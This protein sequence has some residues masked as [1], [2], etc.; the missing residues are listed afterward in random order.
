MIAY[1]NN[2]VAVEADIP[3]VNADTVWAK[4]KHQGGKYTY[5][6]AYY[7]P[8]SDISP[9]SIDDLNTVLNSLPED[10]PVI[11]AGDF[12]ANDI[13]WD[14]NTVKAGSDRGVLCERLIETLDSH[15][16]EQMQQDT[17]RQDASLDLYCTNRP[18]LVLSSNTVPGI[19]DHN[20]I[21]VDSNVKAQQ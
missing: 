7:R 3:Q 12:N 9:D 11:L 18:G 6:G 20:I 13:D 2:L 14:N 10:A 15:Q 8:P 4:V 21:V 19:S 1:K 5:V 17:T 16:L